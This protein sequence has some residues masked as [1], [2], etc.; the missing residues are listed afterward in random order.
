MVDLIIMVFIALA[1]LFE[2]ALISFIIW[3]FS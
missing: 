3:I 1:V 2:I